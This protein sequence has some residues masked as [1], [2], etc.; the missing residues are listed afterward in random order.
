MIYRYDKSKG[1]V[2]H[3]PETGDERKGPMPRHPTLPLPPIGRGIVDGRHYVVAA[4]D[5]RL[6]S[7]LFRA[8]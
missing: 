1:V 6:D 3:Q 7:R 4:L 2:T 5:F 8:W